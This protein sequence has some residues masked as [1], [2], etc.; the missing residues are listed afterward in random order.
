M[1]TPLSEQSPSPTHLS[2]CKLPKRHIPGAVLGHSHL[3]FCS[4][5]PCWILKDYMMK[6]CAPQ[7]TYRSMQFLTFPHLLGSSVK[8]KFISCCLTFQMFRLRGILWTENKTNNQIFIQGCLGKRINGAGKEAGSL[9]QMGLASVGKRWESCR[10]CLSPEL[11]LPGQAHGTRN[12]KYSQKEC[13]DSTAKGSKKEML[14]SSNQNPRKFKTQPPV[15]QSL[16]YP[17]TAELNSPKTPAHKHRQEFC[18]A[19]RAG[20]MAQDLPVILGQHHL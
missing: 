17:F 4:Q 15:Q 13:M 9:S 3:P 10:Q 6:K 20:N 2:L 8:S 19:G 12:S 14:F 5:V 1:N 7:I 16:S 11:V 18:T